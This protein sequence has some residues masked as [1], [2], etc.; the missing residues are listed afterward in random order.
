MEYGKVGMNMEKH[1][2]DE[3]NGLNYTLYGDYYLP[4]LAVPEEETANYGKY[5]MLRKSYLK[6]HKPWYYQSMVLSGKL[7]EHLNMVELLIKQMAVQQ[8][9]T[10][11]LK[12]DAPMV[13][14]QKM[15]ALKSTAEEIVLYEIVYV[16][17]H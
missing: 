17:S 11:Q 13:W 6:E 3:K 8:G 16:M 10:E 1:I 9:I 12:A 4:D 5:G 7:N 15:N 2:Y 14:V